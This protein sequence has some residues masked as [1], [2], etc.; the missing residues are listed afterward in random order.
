MNILVRMPNWLGDAVMATPALNNIKKH[1]PDAQIILL[2]SGSVTAMFEEDTSVI[3]ISDKSKQSKNRVKNIFAQAKELNAQFGEFEH[4]FV[5]TNSISTTFMMKLLN[6]KNL[7]GSKRGLRDL[8]LSKIIQVDI[9]AHQAVIYNQIVN[10]YLKSNYETG[11]TSLVAS[12]S[13]SNHKRLGINAGASYGTAKRWDADRFAEVA[14]AL[15]KEYEIMILGAPNEKNIA[16]IIENILIQ[17]NIKNYQNLVGKTSL[18]ELLSTIACLDLFITNDSGPMHIAG[19]FSIPT[20]AIFGPTK[21]EQTYQW[22]NPKFSL[23]RKE[24]ECAPCMKRD[25]PLKH[26]ECMKFVSVKEVI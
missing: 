19:A 8:L 23:V 12:K 22:G 2:A 6:S 5:F 26:H 16:T 20:V 18:K 9:E 7:V 17:N 15:S 25:C 21:H 3:A 10:G 11:K 13:K 4:I 1:F 14:V 24:I